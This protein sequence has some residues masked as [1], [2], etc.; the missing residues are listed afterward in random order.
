MCPCVTSL[1]FYRNG[2]TNRA[3]F[4]HGS[5]FQPIQHCVVKQIRVPPK[6]RVLPSATLK[7]CYGKWIVQIQ[8]SS[9][10]ELVDHTYDGRRIDYCTAV[11]CNPLNSVSSI[12]SGFVVQVVRTLLCSSWQDFD[13][14][15]ASRG[16][17]AEP[18][19]LV[20]DL[21]VF[22]KWIFTLYEFYYKRVAALLAR[23]SRLS[24]Q[25]KA[26]RQKF[27]PYRER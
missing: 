27:I 11:D 21:A 7:I 4:W 3:A 1:E 17:S 16:P 23:K 25:E 10:I 20:S 15:N 26:L 24:E 5:F 18:K 6:I 2:W 22:S 8:N 9:T 14:H 12:C 13:W 19:L